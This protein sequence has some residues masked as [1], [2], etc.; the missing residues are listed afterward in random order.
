M[1]YKSEKIKLP[2]ELKR[3]VKL[4]LEDR[5][6][7][8]LRR[9]VFGT[10]YN[11]LAKE[12]GVSKRLVQFI[13]N[14]EKEMEAKKRLQQAKKNGKYRYSQK[15]HSEQVRETRRYKQ[16]LYLQGIIKLTQE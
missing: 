1:P 3:N 10:S 8:R 13:C 14:P 7:I 16:N 4:S 6:E 2:R 11:M 15:Y 5:E 12:F 9:A